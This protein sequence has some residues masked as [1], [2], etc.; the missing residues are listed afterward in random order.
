MFEEEEEE[1]KCYMDSGELKQLIDKTF[2]L[3]YLAMKTLDKDSLENEITQQQIQEN[4]VEQ[5]IEKMVDMDVEI[6]EQQLQ[7]M[8]S[9]KYEVIKYKKTAII[10]EIQQIFKKHIEKYETQIEQ[11]RK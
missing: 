7:Q 10:K 9:N 6:T 8:I 11:R 1:S 5:M 3:Q 2:V 4:M